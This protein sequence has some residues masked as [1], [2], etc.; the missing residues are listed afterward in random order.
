MLPLKCF[1]IFYIFYEQYLTIW[2]E[3]IKSLSLS[4]LTIFIIVFV[5]TY[6]N[7]TASL[8]VLLTVT[9]IIV[10]MLALLYFLDIQ[11]NAL[12]LVNIVMVKI[13]SCPKCQRNLRNHS[14]IFLPISE[15][16]NRCR[17]LLSRCDSFLCLK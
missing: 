14:L 3:S 5:L 6:G 1:S 13:L 9:M 11:L 8:I 10:D 12:S 15:Y 17:I 7:L 2:K 4:L 16:W